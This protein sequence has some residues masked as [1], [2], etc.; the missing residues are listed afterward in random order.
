MPFCNVSINA[1]VKAPQNDQTHVENLGL[2]A[3]RL[4]TGV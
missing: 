3:V 4:V 1:S 2:F